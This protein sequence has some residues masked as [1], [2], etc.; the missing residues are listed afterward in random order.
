MKKN[1]FDCVNRD[2]LWYSV[3][4]AGIHGKILTVVK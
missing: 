4:Q 3:M 2:L 1:T